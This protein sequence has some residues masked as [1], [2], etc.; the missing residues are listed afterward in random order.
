[1]DG[2]RRVND[3]SGVVCMRLSS[4]AAKQHSGGHELLFDLRIH[5]CTIVLAVF[6]HRAVVSR[7]NIG[8][9]NRAQEMVTATLMDLSLWVNQSEMEGSESETW[10]D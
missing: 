3:E 7:H 8:L 2:A 10:K 9:S 1:M 4:L 5:D 6:Y